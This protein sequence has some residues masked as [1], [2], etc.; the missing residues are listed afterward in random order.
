MHRPLHRPLHQ[1]LHRPLHRVATGLA[2]L[3]LLFTTL[4]HPAA[5]R[6]GEAPT[7]APNTPAA[8]WALPVAQRLAQSLGWQA[9]ANLD[10]PIPPAEWE[11][12]LVRTLGLDRSG[13]AP[14]GAD[15]LHLL[16]TAKAQMDPAAGQVSR[17]T[18]VSGLMHVLYSF[19]G[20]N[21]MASPHLLGEFRDAAAVGSLHAPFLAEAVAAG[22]LGGFPDGTLRPTAPLSYGEAASLAERVLARYGT[23]TPNRDVPTAPPPPPLPKPPPPGPLPPSPPRAPQ[24]P[25]PP[26]GAHPYPRGFGQGLVLPFT[27]GGIISGGAPWGAAGQTGLTVHGAAWAAALPVIGP[28]PDGHLWVV[29]DLQVENR[30]GAE[31]LPLTTGLR[32]SL[33]DP[34]QLLF[35]YEMDAA[36]TRAL[37]S[38][39]ADPAAS[40]APSQSARGLVAFAVP[41]GTRGI[42]YMVQSALGKDKEKA[43]AGDIW[44]SAM[45]GPLGDL[46]GPERV[47]AAETIPGVETTHRVAGVYKSMAEAAAVTSA[48]RA[49]GIFGWVAVLPDGRYAAVVNFLYFEEPAGK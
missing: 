2:T 13:I 39:F 30:S 25:A 22:W 11:L 19:Y 29:V 15:Y 7:S 41:T 46:L 38:P 14:G 16:L 33:E 10:A 42:W 1:P 21:L 26:S 28:A 44:N 9:P 4:A 49:W 48:A 37:A 32:F 6:A 20:H 18:A 12:L 45:R 3:L 23:T 5:V 27:P 31:S 35:H 47:Y 40:L 24:P 17:Q 8:H 43:K 34:P 36:A